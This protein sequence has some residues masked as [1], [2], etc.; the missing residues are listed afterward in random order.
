[1]ASSERALATPSWRAVSR[2]VAARAMWY[3]LDAPCAWSLGAEDARAA[4]W[5]E[6]EATTSR[7]VDEDD[8]DDDGALL[9]LREARA[10]TLT[11][12]RGSF[13]AHLVDVRDWLAR[14]GA[15]RSVA[16]AG[17]G[18]A[19]YGSELFPC[20]V[21]SFGAH[22]SMF[23]AVCGRASERLMFLYAT[24]SQRK[25]YRWALTRA[26]AFDRETAA[27]NF[28][29]GE[30]T[31]A[32]SGFEIASLA[33]IH[34]ADILSVQTPGRAVNTATAFAMCLVASAAATFREE[35]R[36]G[37]ADASLVDFADA[38]ENDVLDDILKAMVSTSERKSKSAWRELREEAMAR[39]RHR[40]RRT[41][42]D[43]VMVMRA[44]GV[45]N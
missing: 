4:R 1:M 25:F 15:P 18:H 41:R 32:L 11:H 23:R 9:R 33:L 40:L 44:T 17:L 8:L 43:A 36:D 3:A 6:D 10:T 2:A 42:I 30:T 12:V 13:D 35:T 21:A 31:R 14:F 28:Y 22:R 39:A 19:A 20:A 37:D 16:R 24:C 45:L 7:M 34:A 5:D 27:V 26:G 29:T 38:L